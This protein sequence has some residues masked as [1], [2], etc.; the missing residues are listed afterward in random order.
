[1]LSLS[2]SLE[3]SF[4]WQ[5][6]EGESVGVAE[7]S[8]TCENALSVAVFV[9]AVALVSAI[10]SHGISCLATSDAVENSSASLFRQSLLTRANG[11]QERRA[12]Y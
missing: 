8:V 7:R 9:L 5:A 1:M 4:L 3:S 2:L 11:F 12:I 10:I 6:N